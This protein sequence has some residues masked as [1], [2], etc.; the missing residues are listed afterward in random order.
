MHLILYQTTS[1]LCLPGAV[2][3]LDK[4]YWSSIRSSTVYQRVQHRVLLPKRQFLYN[5]MPL[6]YAASDI[7]AMPSYYE[8]APVATV[9]AMAS[10]KPFVGAD[11][12]GI[13]SFIRNNENGLLVPKKSTRELSAAIQLLAQNKVLCEK[14]S[15]QAFSDITHLSWGIQ[16]PR[17]IDVY[18]NIIETQKIVRTPVSLTSEVK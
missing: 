8:G 6:L 16:L 14:L 9:E 5:D 10:G 7:I 17:L 18:K 11:S 3:P 1:T 13:N 4:I 2:N 15:T 12:Q